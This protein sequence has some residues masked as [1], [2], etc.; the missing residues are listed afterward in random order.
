M[1]LVL[2]H[3]LGPVVLPYSTLVHI[4]F[5]IWGRMGEV[6]VYFPAQIGD[7]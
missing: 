4:F 6:V 5:R 7:Q 1:L 3:K 2:K